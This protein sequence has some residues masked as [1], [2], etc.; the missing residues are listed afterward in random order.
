MSDLH[1]ENEGYHNFHIPREAPNLLLVGDI[2]NLKDRGSYLT[3]LEHLCSLFDRV[4]LVPGNHEYFHLD[5]SDAEEIAAEFSDCLGDRFVWMDRQRVELNDKLVILGCTLHSYISRDER[6]D[7]E[8]E[9]QDFCRIGSWS[10]DEH[11]AQHKR[12]RRWLKQQLNATKRFQQ[13]I[14]ATHFPPTWDLTSDPAYANKPTRSFFGSDTLRAFH[15][16]RGSR[17]VTHWIFGHTHWNAKLQI[18]GTSLLSNQ[19][20]HGRSE[21][22]SFDVSAVI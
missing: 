10:V 5:R 2:G 9:I 3:F 17:Q 7:V 4:L 11:N 8:K 21:D 22:Y 13:V 15:K 19:R 16:W 1:L 14:I 20:H 12:D 6:P 18:G